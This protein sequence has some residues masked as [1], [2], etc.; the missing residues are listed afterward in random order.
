MS[1]RLKLP[2]KIKVISLIVLLLGSALTFFTSF[3]V[4]LFKK[5]KAAYIYETSLATSETIQRQL[6]QYFAKTIKD[7]LL[8]NK[9]LDSKSSTRIAKQIFQGHTE[10][11]LFKKGKTTFHNPAQFESMKLSKDQLAELSV[12][13]L[14]LLSKS[15]NGIEIRSLEVE[16]QT[17]FHLSKGKKS[18][19]LFI[20]SQKILLPLE[21]NKIYDSFLFSSTQSKMFPKEKSDFNPIIFSELL[22]DNPLSKS[23]REIEL[24][25]Q[26]FF[27]FLFQSQKFRLPCPVADPPGEGLQSSNIPFKKI[28]LFRNDGSGSWNCPGSSVF[29]VIDQTPGSPL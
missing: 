15:L 21:E 24:N 26:A 6:D 22:K 8:I 29:E 28:P 5:D 11:L 20:G 12:S 19:E 7:F 10:A 4:D 17:L 1:K 23:V 3:S 2:L 14:P 18:A 25:G 16:G 13:D 27:T 9:I